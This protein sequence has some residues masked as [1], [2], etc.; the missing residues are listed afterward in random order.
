[1]PGSKVPIYTFFLFFCSFF[2]VAEVLT[3]FH[4]SGSQVNTLAVMKA[5]VSQEF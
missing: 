1:M 3:K 4:Y 5:T 2:Y